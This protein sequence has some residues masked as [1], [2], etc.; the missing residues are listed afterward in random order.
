MTANL[1]ETVA[2]EA[3]ALGFDAV[4][5]T[6]PDAIGDAGRH[7][8]EFLGSG[9]HGDMAWMEVTADRRRDPSIL[10]PDARSIIM[11]GMSYAPTSDPLAALDEPTRGAISVYA[12]GKDYHD[13]LKAK[14]KTLA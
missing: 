1:K 12:Q 10:W 7:L 8:M 14:L 13:I 6:T 2:R 4:R 5:V 9:R 3:E 11:L